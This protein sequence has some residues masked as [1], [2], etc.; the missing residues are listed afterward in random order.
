MVCH[1]SIF[2]KL[3]KFAILQNKK[4]LFINKGLKCH[5]F[6]ANIFL[7]LSQKQF[8]RTFLRSVKRIKILFSKHIVA[9]KDDWKFPKHCFKKFVVASTKFCYTYYLKNE[10]QRYYFLQTEFCFLTFDYSKICGHKRI[11]TSFHILVQF[12]PEY[13]TRLRKHPVLS[14]V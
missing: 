7:D 3:H 9:Q 2:T 6:W 4:A 10:F 5:V 8:L 13:G 11:R 1:F 14:C 12:C